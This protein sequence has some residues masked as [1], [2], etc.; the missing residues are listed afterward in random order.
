LDISKGEIAMSRQKTAYKDSG[1]RKSP[2]H[3][4]LFQVAGRKRKVWAK[5]RPAKSD[6][7]IV[8]TENDILEGMKRKGYGDGA[9][10]AGAICAGR[11]SDYFPHKISGHFDW[12]DRRFYVADR[13]DAIGLPKSC[14]AYA[15]CDSVAKLFDSQAGLK[16]LLARVR[17]DGPLTIRLTPPVYRLRE[18]G[19]PRGN[20]DTDGPK[21]KSA[22]GHKLR[23]T[24]VAAGWGMAA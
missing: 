7:S 14:V 17:E 9:N 12:L 1:S 24:R 16:K 11:H 18:I 4:F 20:T 2:R 23:L 21:R 3:A 5:V 13:N 10:C 6:V 15:H 22:R 8:L 19:R